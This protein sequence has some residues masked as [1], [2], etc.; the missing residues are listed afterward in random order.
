MGR[1]NNGQMLG[2]GVV[3]GDSP[4]TWDY[5]NLIASTNDWHH[6]VMTYI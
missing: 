4:V 3:T 5:E 6:V 2:G 1:E